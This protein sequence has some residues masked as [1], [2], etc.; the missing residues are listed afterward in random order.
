M[1]RTSSSLA[2]ASLRQDAAVAQVTAQG[3]GISAGGTV[4]G[5]ED[6][7]DLISVEGGG[8]GRGDVLLLLLGGNRKLAGM[9]RQDPTAGHV[10]DVGLLDLI[11]K[12]A[13][14]LA[15]WNELEVLGGPANEGLAVTK[16]L[17]AHDY[18][19]TI[20]LL[21]REPSHGEFPLLFEGQLG[22]GLGLLASG[23]TTRSG[24][25]VGILD[26]CDA[27]VGGS[28]GGGGFADHHGGGVV[29]LI[30]LFSLCKK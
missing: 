10:V 7:T 8:D 25:H 30:V 6:G 21:R 9:V 14:E 5:E 12:R 16:I 28:D 15:Q 19:S 27:A 13:T 22:F 29:L 24:G 26:G 4:E 17:D 23:S 20:F 1:A 2:V 18:I 11:R 3:D